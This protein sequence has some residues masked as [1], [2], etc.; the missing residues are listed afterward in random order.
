MLI[1][2]SVYIILL[3]ALFAVACSKD[4]NSNYTS[5]EQKIFNTIIG[6]W[7]FSRFAT[8]REFKNLLELQ[9]IGVEKGCYIQF[10][11]DSTYEDACHSWLLRPNEEILTDEVAVYKGKFRVYY[12]LK[13]GYAIEMDNGIHVIPHP[14]EI[15]LTA[16]IESYLKKNLIFKIN[17]LGYE[18]YV[19]Y[20]RIK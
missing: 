7:E 8:D 9:P 17:R 15:Y 16:S 18:V 10:H 2:K 1:M 19:E 11:A 12:T 14:D 5:T 13:D 20:K 4:D 6:K 3:M